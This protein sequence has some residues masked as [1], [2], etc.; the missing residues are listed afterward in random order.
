MAGR[1][2]N[3]GYVQ[4]KVVQLRGLTLAASRVMLKGGELN[5]F[6]PMQRSLLAASFVGC[7]L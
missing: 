6:A 3:C 2:V 1:N 5:C 4:A 7:L